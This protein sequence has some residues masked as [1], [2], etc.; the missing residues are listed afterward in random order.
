MYPNL[1]LR[2]FWQPELRPQIFVAMS[3]ADVYERRYRDVIAPAIE[4]ILVNDVSLKPFRVDET[5]TGESILTAIMDGIAHSQMFLADISTVG[6]DSKTSEPYRNGNVMYEVGLALACRQASE[7]LLIRDDKHKL[8]FDVS[9][10]PHKYLDFTDPLR[11][12]DELRDELIARLNEHSYISDARIRLAIAS[13]CAEE[14]TVIE[15][16]QGYK[17]G[18]GFG[19][20][21]TGTINFLSSVAI[22]R[23][24]DK[25]LIQTFAIGDDGHPAYQWTPLGYMVAQFLDGV[26]PKLRWEQTSNEKEKDSNI[27]D[28]DMVKL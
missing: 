23:L 25:K 24:L 18:Q 17:P 11:A 6:N 13:L 21:N 2:T 8:L 9:T 1:Y 4:A 22:P 5:K 7:V 15:L 12:R 19:F 20:R 26:L 28:S 16:F 10:I 3:F 14:K 27:I